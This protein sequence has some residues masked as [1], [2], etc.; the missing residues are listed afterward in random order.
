VQDVAYDSMLRGK[1]Q[2]VH[3]AVARVLEERFPETAETKPEV[4]AQHYCEA[5]LAEPCIECRLRAGQRAAE[6]S[7]NLEAVGHLSRGA[8]GAGFPARVAPA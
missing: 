7:A 6:P 5:G 1:R 3:A 8:R 4:L 2:Q